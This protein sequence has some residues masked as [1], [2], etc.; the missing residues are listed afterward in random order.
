MYVSRICI[1]S[2]CHYVS[3][4]PLHPFSWTECLTKKMLL[5][6]CRFHSPLI[7][8]DSIRPNLIRASHLLR[9]RHNLRASLIGLAYHCTQRTYRTKQM[10]NANVH[11]AP[12]YR[13][14]AALRKHLFLS[15][16]EYS[17]HL[18]HRISSRVRITYVFLLCLMCFLSRIS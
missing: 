10:S 4:P 7:C 9:S 3:P 17:P 8:I 2:F 5:N 6:S 11:P 1:M 15:C 18:R 16:F 14:D 13:V 12:T